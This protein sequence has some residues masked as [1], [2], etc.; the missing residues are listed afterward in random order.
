MRQ[1]SLEKR[2]GRGGK[3]DVEIMDD[4]EMKLAIDRPVWRAVGM[5][6]V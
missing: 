5:G 6:V 2:R 1:A 3:K 4:F